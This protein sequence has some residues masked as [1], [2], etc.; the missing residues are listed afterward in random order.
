MV[1]LIR[2][3]G[4]NPMELDRDHQ[5]LAYGYT[6]ADGPGGVITLRLYD[7]NWPDRDDVTV[8]LSP[9][10]MGQSTGERLLGVITL[11]C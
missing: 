1:G 9:G 11:G 8:S 10:G 2:H 5:V 6:V 3:H 4:L 7:P